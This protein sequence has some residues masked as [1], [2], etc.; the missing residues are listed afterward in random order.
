MMWQPN[1]SG[2]ALSPPLKGRDVREDTQVELV[3]S[4]HSCGQVESKA[5]L[6]Y[7]FLVI[8]NLL[9]LLKIKELHQSFLSYELLLTPD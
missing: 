6:F 5:I 8:F 2:H 9:T 1:Y 4:E 7:A 3:Y